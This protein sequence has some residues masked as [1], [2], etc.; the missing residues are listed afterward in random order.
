MF[1]IHLWMTLRVP[2]AKIPDK[3]G[4][5]E[6]TC[7]NDKV[8]YVSALIISRYPFFLLYP[9]GYRKMRLLLIRENSC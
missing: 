9:A 8:G 1:A 4:C 5:K 3:S 7:G 2:P 6:R